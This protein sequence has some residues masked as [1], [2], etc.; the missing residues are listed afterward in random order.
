MKNMNVEKEMGK[1]IF[2][3][4]NPAVDFANTQIVAHGEP[5]DLLGDLTDFAAWGAAAGLVTPAKANA[6][7]PAWT[8]RGKAVPAPAIELRAALKRIFEDLL[9]GSAVS[10]KDLGAI[11][12]ALN[13]SNA[14]IALRKSGSGFEQQSLHDLEDPVQ[15]LVP[16]AQAAADL[17][18]HGDLANLRKCENPECVLIFYDVTKSH[19]RRWC[20][21][22]TCGNR[23]KASSFYRRQRAS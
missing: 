23:A 14:R 5:L 20:S 10:T 22:A 9:G 2:L 16:V 21:M 12:V 7:L 1:F 13:A 18:C 11:S 8:R 3:G 19:R 17:L 6:L 4:N 15:L